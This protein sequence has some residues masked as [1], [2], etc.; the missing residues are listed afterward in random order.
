MRVLHISPSYAPA[1]IYGGPIQTIERLV[2][3]IELHGVEQRVV[4]TNAN[5]ETTLDV[6]EGWTSR[7]GVKTNYLHRWRAP[8]IAPSVLS[9]A[10][11]SSQWADLVHVSGVFCVTSVLGL[12]AARAAGRPIILS[13]HGALQPV[14][15]QIHQKRKQAWLQMFSRIY[16]NVDIFHATAAHEACAIQNTFGMNRRLVIIPNGDEPIS[17]A[18]V[19]D[20]RRVAPSTPPV[21]GMIGRL[22]PIKAVDRVLDALVIL[23]RRGLTANLEFA[24]PVQDASYRD[25]LLNQAQRI[26]L[27]SHF[28]LLGPLHD[29]DKLRFYARCSVLVVASHSENFGNVVV[30]AL[31]VQTPVVASLGTPWAELANVGCGAWVENQPQ[32]LADAIAPFLISPE[33]RNKA[34]VAGRLLVQQKY[35]WPTVA[36][37]MVETY[38]A[39]IQ[40][41][42]S[43]SGCSRLGC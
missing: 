33:Y 31:N 13:I 42:R 23:H 5:G 20:L 19:S 2:A 7:N 6:P 36:R 11:D 30:E 24:G 37:Q 38:A 40:R 28:K 9:E 3:A 21:I 29:M 14:A 15:M 32:S 27:A 18:I 12:L 41:H 1:Y 43:A 4:T 10:F 16:E 22:H 26:G 8:D 34:G 39:E 25:A 35:T 17:D